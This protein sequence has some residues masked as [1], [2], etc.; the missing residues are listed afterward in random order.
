MPVSST[1]HLPCRAPGV[2]PLQCR[3]LRSPHDHL[4]K[5][6]DSR[7]LLMS[8]PS[9]AGFSRAHLDRDNSSGRWGELP[10][11]CSPLSC[12]CSCMDTMANHNQPSARARA[13]DAASRVELP[14]RKDAIPSGFILFHGP[15]AGQIPR[16]ALVFATE[17]GAR[18]ALGQLR[19]HTS[20]GSQWA[21]LVSTVG[22]TPF[23][24][25]WFGRP[26]PHFTTELLSS[27]MSH[28]DLCQGG[29]KPTPNRRRATIIKKNPVAA[30]VAAITTAVRRSTAMP[31]VSSDERS[32]PISWPSTRWSSRGRAPGSVGTTRWPRASSPR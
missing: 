5:E 21:G 10:M 12:S 9:R 6:G 1:E 26:T 20:S 23:V 30:L 16:T 8:P 29:Q 11:A 2:T 31:P 13:R 3:Q 4:A 19:R 18:A 14:G 24:L 17:E 25:A 27:W 22:S 32:S 7:A 15:E 28:S